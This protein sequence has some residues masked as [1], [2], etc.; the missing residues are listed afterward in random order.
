MEKALRCVTDRPVNI[1]LAPRKKHMAFKALL[2]DAACLS[3]N[4]LEERVGAGA[5]VV[6]LYDV[7]EGIS[8]DKANQVVTAIFGRIRPRSVL[9]PVCVLCVLESFK[10]LCVVFASANLSPGASQHQGSRIETLGIW[11]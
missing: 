11:I 5:R 1:P 4:H 2:G 10:S 3:G 7:L 9:K 6:V 8:E